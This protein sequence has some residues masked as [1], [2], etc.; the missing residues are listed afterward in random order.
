MVTLFLLLQVSS[1]LQRGWKAYPTWMDIPRDVDGKFVLSFT[2]LSQMFVLF[3]A[4]LC[5]FLMIFAQVQ[6]DKMEL[7]SNRLV[8]CST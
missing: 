4:I 8:C 6:L 7:K 3:C 2:P 1:T 5:R